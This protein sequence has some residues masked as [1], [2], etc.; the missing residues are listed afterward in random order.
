MDQAPALDK[1]GYLEFDMQMQNRT[2]RMRI[3]KRDVAY[4]QATGDPGEAFAA[5]FTKFMLTVHGT[6]DE[7][8]VPW[9]AEQ[10]DKHMKQHT[11]VWIQGGNHNFTAEGHRAM[12]VEHIIQWIK[13]HDASHL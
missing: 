13:R 11:L 9:H 1:R 6:E 2:S 4:I 5:V 12:V 8:V 7:D 3:D 10:Y